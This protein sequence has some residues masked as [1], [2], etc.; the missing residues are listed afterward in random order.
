M[1]KLNLLNEEELKYLCNYLEIPYYFLDKKYRPLSFHLDK[2][3]LI[4]RFITFI[5]NKT[6]HIIYKPIIIDDKLFIDK[7]QIKLDVDKNDLI[8]INQFDD[9]NKHIYNLLKKLTNNK[10]KNGNLSKYILNIIFKQNKLI[11]YNKFAKIYL[12]LYNKFIEHNHI[13]SI[14]R[15]SIVDKIINI[16]KSNKL[17][18]ELSKAYPT[19]NFT[20]NDCLLQKNYFKELLIMLDNINLS[21][22]EFIRNDFQDKNIQEFINQ[23]SYTG[24]CNCIKDNFFSDT[25]SRQIMLGRSLD[26]IGCTYQCNK[27]Y[28][29][30][31]IKNYSIFRNDLYIRY[32]NEY[33]HVFIKNDIYKLDHIFPFRLLLSTTNIINRHV[34]KKINTPD[35]YYSSYDNNNNVFIKG[36]SSFNESIVLSYSNFINKYVSDTSLL[37]AITGREICLL[38]YLNFFFYIV[39]K[40]NKILPFILISKFNI[41]Y[42]KSKLGNNMPD[43]ILLYHK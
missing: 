13:L 32:V 18:Y 25:D 8:Y 6:N 15:Q 20:I 5:K 3:E 14:D 39:K 40:N 34:L 16:F 35:E 4:K 10:Y 2:K 11:T 27:S 41:D 31:S 24:I 9:N 33:P 17:E 38:F 23:C 42:I 12:K 43:L 28:F 21:S 7:Q 29:T 22:E 37:G 1:D 36:I 19:F 30:I 26:T